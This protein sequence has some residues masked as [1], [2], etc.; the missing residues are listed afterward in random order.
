MSTYCYIHWQWFNRHKSLA[1]HVLFND[2]NSFHSYPYKYHVSPYHW[3]PLMAT[4]RHTIIR[5]AC[6]LIAFSF[7]NQTQTVINISRYV[8]AQ[9]NTFYSSPCS[10]RKCGHRNIYKLLKKN[11]STLVPFSWKINFSQSRS[12]T[13]FYRVK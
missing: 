6:A 8:N 11:S 7:S 5:F 10:S 2:E 3:S 1:A 13:L 4:E 12:C 9:S